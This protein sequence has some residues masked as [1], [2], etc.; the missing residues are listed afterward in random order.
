[1]PTRKM[2]LV[3]KRTTT[4]RRPVHATAA[5]TGEG[6]GRRPCGVTSVLGSGMVGSIEKENEGKGAMNA[7]IEEKN[8]CF[9][10]QN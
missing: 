7:Y 10:L 2:A 6:Q 9:A 5:M 8:G 1:M 4:A 3:A